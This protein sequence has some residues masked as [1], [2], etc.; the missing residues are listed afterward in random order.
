MKATS[1]KCTVSFDSSATNEIIPINMSKKD[2]IA[3]NESISNAIYIAFKKAN[4][5]V[6]IKKN[7]LYFKK[8]KRP[9]LLGISPT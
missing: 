5:D 4:K 7:N 9:I 6:L 1:T 8:K 3:L 2:L